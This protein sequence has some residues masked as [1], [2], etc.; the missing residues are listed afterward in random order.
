MT[1]KEDKSAIDVK[2]LYTTLINLSLKRGA[3][4]ELSEVDVVKAQY[5]KI[6]ENKYD[7]EVK[8]ISRS[9]FNKALANGC[10]RSV[11]EAIA[12]VV[13]SQTIDKDGKAQTAAV[14]STTEVD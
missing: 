6:K 4:D 8:K 13:L 1:E 2:A 3:F 9:F 5:E 12:L 10:I 14:A 7:D 11:D